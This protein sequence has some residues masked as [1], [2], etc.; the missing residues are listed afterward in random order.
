M[1]YSLDMKRLGSLALALLIVM[2]VLGP[3]CLV[4]ASSAMAMPMDSELVPCETP[5]SSMACPYER[6]DGNVVQKAAS[7]ESL[8]VTALLPVDPSGFMT[9]SG[10]VMLDEHPTLDPPPSHLTPLRI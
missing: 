10:L 6:P 5:E 9:A 1:A 7:D 4:L 8:A 3:V 2:A